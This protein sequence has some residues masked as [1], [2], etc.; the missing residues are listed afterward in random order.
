[1]SRVFDD[2][3]DAECITAKSWVDKLLHK[4]PQTREF[5]DKDTSLGDI[6]SRHVQKMESL[7]E[8]VTKAA[9]RCKT[10]VKSNVQD[11]TNIRGQFNIFAQFAFKNGCTNLNAA[12]SPSGVPSIEI[13]PRFGACFSFDSR[14]AT[15]SRKSGF[16]RLTRPLTDE[17]S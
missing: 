12:L 10:F 16:S 4:A 7:E 15:R 3:T 6:K 17:N 8:G 11:I 9:D 14:K 5:F 1:M 13:L 2:M